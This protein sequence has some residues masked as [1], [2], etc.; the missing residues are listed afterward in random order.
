MLPHHKGTGYKNAT[1]I[2]AFAL[3][4]TIWFLWVIRTDGPFGRF[5]GRPRTEW[6]DDGR[7]EVLLDDFSYVDP[8]GSRWLAPKGSKTDGASIPQR[9]WSLIGGPYSGKYKYAALIHDVAC[10]ERTRTSSDVHRMFYFACRC[11]GVSKTKAMLMYC[12]VSCKGPSWIIVDPSDLPAHLAV[13]MTRPFVIPLPDAPPSKSESLSFLRECEEFLRSRDPDFDELTDFI[14]RRYVS[15]RE[16]QWFEE[17]KR[18]E[19]N[20]ARKYEELKKKGSN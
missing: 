2:T 8:S 6:L 7:T 13:S 18:Q 5:V 19:R 20:R 11:G 12:A 4:L 16:R 14:N 10:E 9:F 3:L 1:G 17:W 15:E